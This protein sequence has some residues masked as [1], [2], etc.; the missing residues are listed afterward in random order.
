MAWGTALP[1]GEGGLIPGQSASPPSGGWVRLSCLLTGTTVATGSTTR[2]REQFH[3][4]RAGKS[5]L[6]GC[7]CKQGLGFSPFP[8]GPSAS[9]SHRKRNPPES[10]PS[11]GQR[12]HRPQGKASPRLS[13][14]G[15]SRWRPWGRVASPRPGLLRSLRGSQTLH[16]DTALGPGSLPLTAGPQLGHVGPWRGHACA[17][18]PHSSVRKPREALGCDTGL[19]IVSTSSPALQ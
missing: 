7:P 2:R 15:H 9:S 12:S 8:R 6:P 18:G 3:V 14:W 4:P 5:Q 11:R 13:G 17:S 1:L 16:R 10:R 19:G